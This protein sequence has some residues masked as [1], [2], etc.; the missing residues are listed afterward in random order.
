MIVVP[1]TTPQTSG[2]PDFGAVAF[3]VI[4]WPGKIRIFR[5]RRRVQL[6]QVTLTPQMGSF[7]ADIG[8]RGHDMG[9]QF[10]LHIQVPLL[11][12][13]PHHLVRNGIEAGREKAGARSACHQRSGTREHV[14]GLGL[15]Q[16]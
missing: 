1:L 14:L 11:H 12:V 9:W 16:G 8:N 5:C 15:E 4:G 13:G 10:M 6:V 7:A 2:K 3:V